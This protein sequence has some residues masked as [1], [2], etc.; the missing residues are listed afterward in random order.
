MQL[1]ER[2]FRLNWRTA[3][4]APKPCHVAGTPKARTGEW[5]GLEIHHPLRDR[6]QRGLPE[7]P[8]AGKRHVPRHVSVDQ[9]TRTFRFISW[10]VSRFWVSWF[11]DTRGRNILA[12]GLE[13]EA[14]GDYRF[15]AK[16]FAAVA[17]IFGHPGRSSLGSDWVF[18]PVK[19][20]NGA[21]RFARSYSFVG[22]SIKL[23][24]EN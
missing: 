1:P 20:R 2:A 11:S 13:I 19:S 6:T 9:K 8:D 4:T 7:R 22:A 14:C 16:Y 10:G 3:V 12:V 17:K 5:Q 21:Q 18:F 23:H 15:F 24:C